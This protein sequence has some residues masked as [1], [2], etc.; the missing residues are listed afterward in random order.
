MDG[1]LRR[2]HA[3]EL[4]LRTGELRQDGGAIPL[5][6]Q[7]ALALVL[8]V[9]NAGRLVT[10]AELQSAIW[11]ADTHVDF[12]RGLNYCL[13]QIRLA[14]GDDARAPRFV[15][16]V[17]RQGYR[18]M[19]PISASSVIPATR[20]SVHRS[21]RMVAAAVLAAVLAGG[22]AAEAGPRNEDHHR[23]AIQLA[24]AVHDF[25]F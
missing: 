21:R 7:P 25:L 4:N 15:E 8:L 23:L 17:P 9:T 10:R 19:A 11:P 14:L 3:F 12:E 18:F 24:T 22:W 2:F 6:R 13:R 20:T 16:T 5:E 1:Q